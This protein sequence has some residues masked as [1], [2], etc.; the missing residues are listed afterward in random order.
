MKKYS[1]YY[2]A[3]LMKLVYIRWCFASPLPMCVLVG[4][5]TDED[6]DCQSIDSVL[7]ASTPSAI[8]GFEFTLRR[9]RLFRFAATDRVILGYRRDVYEDSGYRR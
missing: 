3:P 1:Q 5:G 4:C 2:H 7:Q 6:S 9:I 8:A